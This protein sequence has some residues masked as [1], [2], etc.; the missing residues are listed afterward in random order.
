MDIIQNLD[1]KIVGPFVI[2]C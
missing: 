2:R 1:A